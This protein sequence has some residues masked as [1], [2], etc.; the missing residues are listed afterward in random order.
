MFLLHLT[1]ENSVIQVI[2]ELSDVRGQHVGAQDDGRVDISPVV[3]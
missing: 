3:W 1:A 2:S